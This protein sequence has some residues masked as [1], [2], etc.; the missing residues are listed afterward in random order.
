MSNTSATGGFLVPDTASLGHDAL[1]D[2]LRATVAGI[3]GLDGSLVR[4]RFQTTPAP[5]PAQE[6]DWCS[7]A[8][9]TRSPQGLPAAIHDSTDP[10]S[11]TVMSWSR[12][13]VQCSFYGPLSNDL[14]TQLELGLAVS[15]NRQELRSGGLALVAVG[16]QMT[17]PELINDTWVNRVELELI[18][19]VEARRT[20]PVQNILGSQLVIESDTGRTREITLEEGI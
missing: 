14:A 8:V 3:T 10:G 7:M 5:L 17:V 20:Y 2:L 11:D 13:R 9:Q 12:L 16:D 19:D 18:F 6:I 4:P 15:Q 1:E